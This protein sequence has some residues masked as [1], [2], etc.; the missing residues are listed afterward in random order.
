[1]VGPTPTTVSISRW[2]PR[3]T[4]IRCSATG[5]IMALKTSAI[6]AVIYRCGAS[7]MRACQATE[8]ASTNACSA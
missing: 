8:A 4:M 6:P 7:W 5:M 1:M 3:R 2:M